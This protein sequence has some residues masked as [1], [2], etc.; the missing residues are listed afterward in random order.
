MADLPPW[1]PFER[2]ASPWIP[3]DRGGG[4]VV[5]LLAPSVR[6]RD[7]WSGPLA[8]DLVE[9]WA[10]DG[11][12]V[13]LMD[14]VYEYPMLHR[15]VGLDNVDG[16]TDAVSFGASMS[17]VA[18]PVPERSFFFVSAGSPAGSPE[19]VAASPR[20]QRIQDG[21]R[22]AGAVLVLFLR[23][24]CASASHGVRGCDDLV[25][26]VGE[27]EK[28][29]SEALRAGDKIR[30]VMGPRSRV[31][32]DQAVTEE[33]ARA[34]GEL[35][36]PGE[37]DDAPAWSADTRADTD[38]PQD[39]EGPFAWQTDS[40]PQ[41]DRPGEPE[42]G[43]DLVA[44]PDLEE[45]EV[46]DWSD[47]LRTTGDA[48]A[49]GDASV[50]MPVQASETSG[51]AD[52]SDVSWPEPAA[53]AVHDA[54]PLDLTSSASDA[55]PSLAEAAPVPSLADAG[56]P[57]GVADPAVPA[58]PY[59]PSRTPPS[60]SHRARGRDGEGAWGKLLWIAI[61]AVVLIVAALFGGLV[62]G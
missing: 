6:D 58:G 18:R 10:R 56:H 15:S 14:G 3:E 60:R 42:A 16:V 12:R 8:V 37:P 31:T 19:A 52:A 47:L 54:G 23:D 24:G 9:A 39:R 46:T 50:E 49:E 61:A 2:D 21:F 26:L 43:A 40:E 20:W 32:A 59:M 13:V 28:L 29:P 33:A 45:P 25:V 36:G 62:L 35:D 51:E 30:G 41:P 7:R 11:K 57:P 4:R 27:G 5:A 17:H 22:D 1:Q 34:H 44:A 55:E 38:R 48:E 53:G